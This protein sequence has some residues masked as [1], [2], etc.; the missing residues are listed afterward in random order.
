MQHI[1]DMSAIYKG[2][3]KY[4]KFSHFWSIQVKEVESKVTICD[5]LLKVS[6]EWL[7]KLK[8]ELANLQSSYEATTIELEA[9]VA[10]KEGML[11]NN[12]AYTI[13]VDTQLA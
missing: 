3:N 13:E 5:W 8:E 1:H 2:L 6:K 12:W 9:Q 11:A 4:T 10:E 7:A